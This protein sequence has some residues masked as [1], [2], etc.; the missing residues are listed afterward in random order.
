MAA[1]GAVKIVAGL[2]AV[3]MLSAAGWGSWDRFQGQVLDAE[4]GKPIPEA[5][6]VFEWVKRH[7]LGMDGPE[8]VQNVQEVVTDEDGR[9]SVKASPGINWNPITY[10]H[11]LKVVTFALGYEPSALGI[12]KG[13]ESSNETLSKLESGA[14]TQLQRLKPS[15][16]TREILSLGWWFLKDAEDRV[17]KLTRAFN[18]QRRRLGLKEIRSPE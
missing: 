13:A 8:Y 1:K 7:R 6:V 12:T 14:V 16:H 17:P 4:T 18:E 2:I 5:V 15:S 9:F 11:R 3:C 10:L